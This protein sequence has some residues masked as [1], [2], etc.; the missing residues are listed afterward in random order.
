M[1]FSIAKTTEE[2]TL[3][4]IPLM[5]VNQ[6]RSYAREACKLIRTQTKAIIQSNET[7]LEPGIL[8]HMTKEECI[9]RVIAELGD[10]NVVKRDDTHKSGIGSKKGKTSK[11]H[12]TFWNRALNAWLAQVLIKGKK[13]SIP[14]SDNEIQCAV[15]VDMLLDENNNDEKRPRNYEDF[16]EILEAL[17]QN[18]TSPRL[19]KYFA[20]IDIAD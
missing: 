9:G 11:Y 10:V 16:P 18:Y 14:K 8:A 4:D 19:Q 20:K 1:N 12:Y 17:P 5:D 7:I 3:E 13:Y 2:I 6:I 15:A